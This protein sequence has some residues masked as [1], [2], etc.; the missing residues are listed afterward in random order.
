MVFVEAKVL[1]ATH[2]EL[3]R[4][5]ALAF[6][7]TVLVSVSESAPND[8]ERDQWLAMAA[9]SLASAY[10]DTEPDYPVL[11]VKEKNPDYEL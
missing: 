5:I 3:S 1:D 10:G 4:P 6:G 7:T 8:P 2:L 9:S 11:L